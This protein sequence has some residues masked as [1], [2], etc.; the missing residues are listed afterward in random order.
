MASSIQGC[1][2]SD[3]VPVMRPKQFIDRKCPTCGNFVKTPNVSHA[4]ELPVSLALQLLWMKAKE[5]VFS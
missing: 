1:G 2:Q 3:P 5:S 4:S